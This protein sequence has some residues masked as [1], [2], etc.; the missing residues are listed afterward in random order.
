[1]QNTNKNIRYVNSY[2]QAKRFL[3]PSNK[4]TQPHHYRCMH[5]ECACVET[6]KTIWVACSACKKENN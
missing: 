6:K 5:G 1:M 4:Y 2:S 3:N